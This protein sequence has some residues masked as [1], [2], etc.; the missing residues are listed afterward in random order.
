[1]IANQFGMQDPFNMS[2][3][4]DN[5]RLIPLQFRKPFGVGGSGIGSLR[6]RSNSHPVR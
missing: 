3:H 6:T 1:M 5:V 2:I 4:E